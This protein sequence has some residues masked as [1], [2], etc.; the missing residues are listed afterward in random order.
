MRLYM[1][2]I[3]LKLCWSEKANVQQKQEESGERLGLLRPQHVESSL[4]HAE[5]HMLRRRKTRAAT[6]MRALRE[7]HKSNYARKRWASFDCHYRLCLSSAG[8]GSAL[9]GDSVCRVAATERANLREKWKNGSQKVPEELIDLQARTYMGHAGQTGRVID[10][11]MEP[12]CP[13]VCCSYQGKQLARPKMA[14]RSMKKRHPGPQSTSHN[15]LP[16]FM[17]FNLFGKTILVVNKKFRLF[18]PSHSGSETMQSLAGEH[19]FPSRPPEIS[20]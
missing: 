14:T 1:M 10:R 8:R 15:S 13:D 7:R 2:P 5:P 3:T 6:G 19:P 11:Y 16:G 4:V 18:W 12:L 17:D 9:F 20:R